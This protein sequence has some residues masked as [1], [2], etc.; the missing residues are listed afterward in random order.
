MNKNPYYQLTITPKSLWKLSLAYKKIYQHYFFSFIIS[1]PV[2]LYLAY[3][4]YVVLRYM[5]MKYYIIVSF[6]LFR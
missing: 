2:S 4:L 1:R 6:R 3:P 5:N